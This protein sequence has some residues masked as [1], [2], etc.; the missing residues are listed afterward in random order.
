MKIFLLLLVA[1]ISFGV[2]SVA[3]FE[4]KK[5]DIKS[6]LI[7]KIK[8]ELEKNGIY[9]LSAD[10]VGRGYKTKSVINLKGT[11]LSKK[12]KDKALRIVKDLPGVFDVIDDIEIAK[13]KI[14]KKKIVFEPVMDNLKLNSDQKSIKKSDI[15]NSISKN[16]SVDFSLEGL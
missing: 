3:C 8:K 6:S 16:L 9:S 13:E 11:L 12:E 7:S 10:L 2:L 14:I 15:K 1:F 5:N 4:N